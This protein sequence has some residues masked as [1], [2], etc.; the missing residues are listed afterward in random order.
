ML[1]NF[2]NSTHFYPDSAAPHFDVTSRLWSFSKTRSTLSQLRKSSV[3]IS[4]YSFFLLPS[5]SF[6]FFSFSSRI[7]KA[8]K[9]G[10]ARTCWDAKENKALIVQHFTFLQGLA[11]NRETV[12]V[13]RRHAERGLEPSSLEPLTSSSS[14]SSSRFVEFAYVTLPFCRLCV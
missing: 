3:K 13:R 7:R 14:S 8:N 1:T 4:G 9:S 6:F 12:T 11:I 10:S 5:F 2:I